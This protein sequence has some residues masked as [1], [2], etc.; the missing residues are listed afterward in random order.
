MN[1]QN[2]MDVEKNCV[3]MIEA[4]TIQVTINSLQS[5]SGSL[6]HKYLIYFGK[7]PKTSGKIDVK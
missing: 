7:W 2:W 4:V 1:K 3:C 5:S 6:L